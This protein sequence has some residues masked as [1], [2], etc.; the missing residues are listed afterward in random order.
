[1]RFFFTNY[2]FATGFRDRVEFFFFAAFLLLRIMKFF[3]FFWSLN[4]GWSF[5]VQK[6]P[7]TPPPPPRSNGAPLNSTHRWN[8]M[9]VPVQ[10][11]FTAMSSLQ[12]NVQSHIFTNPLL[13][14][15][16]NLQHIGGF[17]LSKSSQKY[18][19]TWVS[20]LAYKDWWFYY[21]LTRFYYI[22]TAVDFTSMAASSS[23]TTC[24]SCKLNF[25]HNYLKKILW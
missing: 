16:T 9:A 15:D 10:C 18:N 7:Y 24:L 8:V 5:F 23:V 21:I 17:L 22:L 11:H 19:K 1:M 13:H 4:S 14:A 25:A 6:L 3:F 20:T 2:H 12:W